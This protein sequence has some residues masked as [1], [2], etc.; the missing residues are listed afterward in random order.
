MVLRLTI[1][2]LQIMDAQGGTKQ[3]HVIRETEIAE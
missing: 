3:E 1:G 2:Y